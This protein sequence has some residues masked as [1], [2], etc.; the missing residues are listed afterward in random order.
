MIPESFT[1]TAERAAAFTVGQAMTVI[2][3][4]VTRFYHVVGKELV[5]DGV[6]VLIEADANQPCECGCGQ[7]GLGGLME[8][9]HPEDYRDDELA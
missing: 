8:A 3:N 1:T 7:I 5:P 6:K 2:Y 4:D 9:I